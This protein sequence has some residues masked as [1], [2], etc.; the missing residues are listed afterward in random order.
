MGIE[1]SYTSKG[2]Q[3]AEITFAITIF[4]ASVAFFVARVQSTVVAAA[5]ARR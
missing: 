2:V 3:V 4:S 5:A 1:L